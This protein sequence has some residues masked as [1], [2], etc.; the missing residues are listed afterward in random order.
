MKK[1]TGRQTNI[2]IF[3]KKHIVG[4]TLALISVIFAIIGA[5]GLGIGSPK[6]YYSTDTIYTDYNDAVCFSV[7]LKN[8][9][10]G[11]TPKA[12]WVNYAGLAIKDNS[13]NT[14]KEFTLRVGFATSKGSTFTDGIDD[15]KNTVE[16]VRPGEWQLMRSV[17][18]T[19][20]PSQDSEVFLILISSL[21][22]SKYDVKIN[23]IALTGVDPSGKPMV[24]NL[25]CEGSGAKGTTSADW[26][27]NLDSATSLFTSE[28]AKARG[29]SLIDE[30]NTFDI[31]RVIIE[32]NETKYQ[33]NSACLL[34]SDEYFVMEGI[35]SL[36]EGSIAYIDRE[37]NPLGAYIL[38]L[39]TLFG[40]NAFG[41]R[42]MPYIFSILT[43]I[44]LF[45]LGKTMFNSNGKGLLL[46]FIYA[47]SGIALGL[48]TVGS[49][50]SIST[51]FIVM[52]LTFM[53]KFYKRGISSITN[54]GY[55]NVILSGIMFA[56]AVAIKGTAV[57]SI[58]PIL[59]I[60]AFGMN[61]QYNAYKYRLKMAN[62]QDKG[63]IKANYFRKATLCS[64]LML[65]F[66]LLFTITII[67]IA[68]IFARK[69]YSYQYASS[70][71]VDLAFRLF[72]EGFNLS[73]SYNPLGWIVNFGG[74]N[75]GSG[76]VIF[77]NLLVTIVNLA[78]LIFGIYMLVK[79]LTNKKSYSLEYKHN[80]VVPFVTLLVGLFASI[81]PYLFIGGEIS[82][83]LLGSIFAGAISVTMIDSIKLKNDKTLF[84][85]KGAQINTQRL[86]FIIL[87]FICLVIFALSVSGL[88]G[89]GGNMGIYSWN[90]IAGIK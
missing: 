68:P 83:Y 36:R 82:N 30:Q 74:Q 3:I 71:S 56:L 66:A 64:L 89:L 77:A 12:L 90:M 59:T 88:L 11:Y 46:S 18:G 73:S 35:R 70:G 15:V 44:A 1:Q 43:I 5:F 80:K 8:E 26:K 10:K 60:F 84:T 32:G 45:Y 41:I 61:R 27:T 48:A 20:V 33:N 69:I 76:K 2:S 86:I 22:I 13:V 85:I 65:Y 55:S 24:F 75:L 25:S 81:I 42:L 78:L 62:E 34:R 87:G 52:A 9:Y 49:T 39:G 14:A 38:A 63:T 53:F 57:F 40:Y 23:E 79:Y 67:V 47:I 31:N 37:T 54:K 7:D 72:R 58:A 50:L 51:F 17:I 19:S 21:S 4:L 29:N 6:T 16:G 28:K